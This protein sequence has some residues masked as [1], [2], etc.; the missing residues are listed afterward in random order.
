MSSQAAVRQRECSAEVYCGGSDV[1]EALAAEWRTLCDT[2]ISDLP[3]YRPEF[4][5]AFVRAF[6]PRSEIVLMAARS[7]EELTGLLP[8]VRKTASFCGAPARILQGAANAHS[9][10]FDL[11]RQRGH[12]GER[13]VS[14]IWDLA[15]RMGNWDVMELPL[16]PD[17][18]SAHEML[19]LAR[20]DGFLTGLFESDRS[21]YIPLT[22]ADSGESVPHD[23][24][25][26]QN[27]RRRG[28][29]ARASAE[30]RLERIT[31]P[32]AASLAEFY[33]LEQSGWKGQRGTAIA[34]SE[35]TR[36]FYDELA[37]TAAGQGY[38]SL[39]LLRLGDKVAAGHYGLSYRGRYYSPKV[40]YDESLSQLGPGH[41]I[42]QSIL[43]DILGRGFHEFDFVGPWM[44]WK[45]EW[46]RGAR[47]HNY[48]YIFQPS[49]RG[50]LL[51]WLRFQ[52]RPV[53]RSWYHRVRR[54]T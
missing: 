13:A 38:F 45:A 14:D 37:R 1:I 9:C 39:Y 20:E 50:K 10:R 25:F 15:K 3:F 49:A 24:H 12:A 22:P 46:A 30:L 23:S 11:L 7:G 26:R 43:D 4:I 28:R 52:V 41:L 31:S 44:E 27:L 33:E 5:K 48:C 19:A 8:L 42:V 2:S 53:V 32:D 51:H 17:G 16:V 18:G 40:A 34:D 35:A 21:A 47:C 6:E 36:R 29:K 54:W